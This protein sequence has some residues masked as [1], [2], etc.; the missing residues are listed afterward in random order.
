MK[1]KIITND[2]N[3]MYLNTNSSF[4]SNIEKLLKSTKGHCPKKEYTQS[5]ICPCKDLYEKN[6]CVCNLY[7]ENNL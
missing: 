2:G 5:N 3:T 7:K 6:E 4:V 1:K